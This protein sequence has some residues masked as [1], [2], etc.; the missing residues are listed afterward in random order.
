MLFKILHFLRGYVRLKAHGGF[1]ERF[2]NLCTNRGIPLWE[3]ESRD[4]IMFANTT[5]DGY[6]KIR[7]PAKKS[8]MKVRISKKY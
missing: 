7:A 8:G 1:P 2:L 5:P 4:G 6:R 3:V